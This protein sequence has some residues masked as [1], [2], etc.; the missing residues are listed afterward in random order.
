MTDWLF[1]KTAKTSEEM[2]SSNCIQ[3]TS[4]FFFFLQHYMK[5]V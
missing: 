5:A 4:V 3:M 1:V 2:I